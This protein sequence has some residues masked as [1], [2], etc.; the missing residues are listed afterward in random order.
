[1]GGHLR[2]AN[3]KQVKLIT[4]ENGII[5]EARGRENRPA[6]ESTELR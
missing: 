6:M 3:L 4:K 5:N 1:M 2:E